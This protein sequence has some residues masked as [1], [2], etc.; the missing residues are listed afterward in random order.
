MVNLSRR[1]KL[2]YQDAS[3]GT[4]IIAETGQDTGA[5]QIE[6]HVHIRKVNN[7]DVL[8]V[9]LDG[10]NFGD[11]IPTRLSD[12][13]TAQNG[14]SEPEILL[15]HYDKDTSSFVTQGRFY[16]KNSGTIND[17]GQLALKLYSFMKYTA[18]QSVS[19]GSITTNIEAALN[20]VL[21]SGYVA[22]V[23]AGVTPPSV[24]DY[25]LNSRREKGLQELTRNYNYALTFTS[26]LDSNNDYKVKFEPVGQ[27]GTVD[28]ISQDNV[29]DGNDAV[30]FKSWQK[31]KTESIINKV[32]VQGTNSNGNKIT[33][34]ATNQTQIDNFGEKFRK[35][36]IGYIENLAEATTIAEKFLVPGLDDSGN[37]ITKVPESGTL[38]TVVYSDNVVN[39]SF[40]I[41]DAQR[42]IDDTYTCVQQRNYWPEGASELEFE[43][44]QEGLEKEAR[45][46]ENLRDERG[47][48]Y[49][50][51]SQ[52]VGPLG[53]NV[54]DAEAQTTSSSSND[55]DNG[56]AQ[57]TS[58]SESD[59]ASAQTSSSTSVDLNEISN[60]DTESA[61]GG[62]SQDNSIDSSQWHFISETN[63]ISVD[64][65]FHELIVRVN[66]AQP[67]NVFDGH[68]V[69]AV[70]GGSPVWHFTAQQVGQYDSTGV[71]STPG[72]TW[73]Q[74]RSLRS[75]DD[76]V[77]ETTNITYQLY[78]RTLNGTS[79]E[80][81]AEL[82]VKGTQH[83]HGASTSTS[84]SGHGSSSSPSEHVIS[85]STSDS[86]HGGKG[87]PGDHNVSTT[88]ST[89]DSGHGSSN[90][91][92][93]GGDTDQGS[94]DAAQEDKTH[95]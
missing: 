3:T 10:N 5:L 86:G 75:V 51:G 70:S 93:H 74:E 53:L 83:D 6:R 85:T 17:N 40:A 69:V 79:T 21:P 28:T 49:P 37:D 65:P 46:K 73:L 4:E 91:D 72:S 82:D 47:L 68:F 64:T 66:N 87:E 80:I 56:Q 41:K 81:D 31:D 32:T 20:A 57:T 19:T 59:N 26:E 77:S 39:D 33:A 29:T 67:T 90:T 63:G 24:N 95:R 22:D 55:Y 58:S 43:F 44:E 48:L 34:T 12:F 9:W 45:D 15:K 38:K 71:N 50:E 8:K 88:T 62:F 84:D 25:S 76:Y 14:E 35:F 52:D 61:G 78:V 36:K 92:P 2:E 54:G 27:G 60:F 23:P 7:P 18:E 1:F 13:A 16:A 42:N 94:V 89:S 30:K 11:S